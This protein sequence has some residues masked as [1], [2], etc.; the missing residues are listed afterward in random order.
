M[1]IFDELIKTG[2]WSEEQAQLGVKFK[3]KCAYCAKDMLSCVDNHSEWQ[4]D[5]IIPASDGGSDTEENRAL[6]CRT[7]NFIKGRW[8]PEK[9][10]SVAGLGKNELM[11]IARIYILDKRRKMEADLEVYKRIIA[12]N[13]L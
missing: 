10:A 8:N 13:G 1:R 9:N 11:E 7:C 12:E 6:S 2:K 4:S 5:H 3:F